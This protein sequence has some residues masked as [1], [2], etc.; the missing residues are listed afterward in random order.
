VTS[1]PSWIKD[2]ASNISLSAFLGTASNILPVANY[3]CTLGNPNA[4]WARIYTAGIQF[5]AFSS[6]VLAG[7]YNDL[8]DKPVITPAWDAITGKPDW[9]TKLSSAAT[10]IVS[11]AVIHPPTINSVDLG[12]YEKRWRNAYCAYLHTSGGIYF[13]NSLEN[14]FLGSYNELTD[15]PVHYDVDRLPFDNFVADL[16]HSFIEVVVKRLPDNRFRVFLKSATV[17]GQLIPGSPNC[18]LASLSLFVSVFKCTRAVGGDTYVDPLS[19]QED[20]GAYQKFRES[21][22]YEMSSL[23]LLGSPISW[24][25][26]LMNAIEIPAAELFQTDYIGRTVPARFK[27]FLRGVTSFGTIRR[28]VQVGRCEMYHDF[29]AQLPED[30]P[31]SVFL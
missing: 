8:R 10:G 9:T 14:P 3:A 22:T 25:T 13:S 19:T 6:P 29:V 16:P 17:P 15:L 27:V 4:Q 26:G 20:F 7:S 28:N 23:A 11:T 31:V 2:D 5:G 12:T 24:Y 30:T 21:K 18:G 1:K